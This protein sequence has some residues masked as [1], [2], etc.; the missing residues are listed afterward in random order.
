MRILGDEEVTESVKT[1]IGEARDRGFLLA[2]S[3][4]IGAR[5]PEVNLLAARKAV[6]VCNDKYQNCISTGNLDPTHPS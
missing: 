1:A 4:V 5:S 3:C 2:P 6:N